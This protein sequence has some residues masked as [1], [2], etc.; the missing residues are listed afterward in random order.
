[1]SGE[2][3]RCGECALECE[4]E[5][6][7]TK[8][9]I[10]ARLESNKALFSSPV[11]RNF[12]AITKNQY[13]VENKNKIVIEL[14]SLGSSV[15]ITNRSNYKLIMSAKSK[16]RRRKPEDIYLVP[17]DSYIWINA[18]LDLRDFYVSLED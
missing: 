9:D 10:E 8:E 2:C 7:W 16:I 14:E 17:A 12:F 4:C 6:T 5:E 1:M 11:R 13:H 18:E 15:R 3:K